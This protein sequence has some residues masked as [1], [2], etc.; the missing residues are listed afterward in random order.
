MHPLVVVLF[1]ITAIR[2]GQSQ[3]IVMAA[4]PSKVG[5]RLHITS[6]V[7]EKYSVQGLLPGVTTEDVTNSLEFSTTVLGLGS[8]SISDARVEIAKCLEQRTVDKVE[9]KPKERSCTGKAFE[10][11]FSEKKLD[12][13]SP[14]GT[15]FIPEHAPGVVDAFLDP[16]PLSRCLAGKPIKLQDRIEVPPD[17][18]ESALACYTRATPVFRPQVKL[19]LVCSGERKH[20]N[21][22]CVAFQLEGEVV[23]SYPSVLQAVADCTMEFKGEMLVSKATC[24]IVQATCTGKLVIEPRKGKAPKIYGTGSKSWQYAA[25]FR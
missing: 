15:L 21:V 24:A 23:S 5:D 4:R 7:A 16:T 9:T 20:D 22:D 3:E 25:D 10:F 8:E 6:T 1:L 17:I 18:A 19:I 2:P 11:H 12:V 14:P 13:S